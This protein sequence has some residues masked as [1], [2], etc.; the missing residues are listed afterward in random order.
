MFTIPQSGISGHC[1]GVTRRS[2]L[3]AGALALGGLTLADV[4][5]AGP[6]PRTP[7]NRGRRR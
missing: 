2:F 7:Q 3:E 6:K 4:V 5:A 1:D